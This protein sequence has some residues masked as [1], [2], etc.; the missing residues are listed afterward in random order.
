MQRPKTKFAQNVKI[1]ALNFSYFLAIV[2]AILK[3]VRT[4]DDKHLKECS[5]TNADLKNQIL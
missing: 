4:D 1:R 5:L 3:P 2:I